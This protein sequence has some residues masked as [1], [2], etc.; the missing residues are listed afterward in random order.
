[1][2]MA[3][4]ASNARALSTVNSRLVRTLS[5]LNLSL[6]IGKIQSGNVPPCFSRGR[7]KDFATKDSSSRT[8]PAADHSMMAE[9]AAADW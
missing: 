2:V 8:S 7:R 5:S 6:R 4:V 9:S 3:T 1:M